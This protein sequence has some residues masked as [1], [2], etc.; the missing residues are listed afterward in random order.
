MSTSRQWSLTTTG[1][2]PAI[3]RGTAQLPAGLLLRNDSDPDGDSLTVAAVGGALNGSVSMAGGVIS[4]T[5]TSSALGSFQYT[6]NDGQGGSSQ[7]SVGVQNVL[8]TESANI[9]NVPNDPTLFSYVD[10]RGATTV[11]TVAADGTL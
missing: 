8:T 2:S 4:F 3:S 5:T 1:S 7:G 6:V 9:V 11:S 10:G